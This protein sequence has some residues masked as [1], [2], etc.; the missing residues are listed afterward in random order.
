MQRRGTTDNTEKKVWKGVPATSFD[1]ATLF[2]TYGTATSR[3]HSIIVVD[4]I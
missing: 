4:R 2:D 1:A 3:F